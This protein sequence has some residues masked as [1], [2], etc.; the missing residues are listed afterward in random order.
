MILVTGGGG[1]L[2]VNLIRVLTASG[3]EVRAFDLPN[4]FW[5]I[6]E[7]IQGVEPFSGDVTDKKLVKEACSD[8]DA[9]IHLAALLPTISEDD[10]ELTMSV[11]VEGTRNITAALITRQHIPLIF[12]SSTS[13]YRITANEMH[14]IMDDH[15][16][17]LTTCILRARSRLRLSGVRGSPILFFASLR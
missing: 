2:G 11:N 14:P 16:Q 1:R 13:T 15:P 17:S 6:I 12:A 3:Y 5:E 9:V 4:I 10:R 8:V 7:G